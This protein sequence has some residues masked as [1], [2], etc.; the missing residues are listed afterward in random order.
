MVKKRG[1][2]KSLDALL[3]GSMS[4]TEGATD[5]LLENNKEKLCYLPLDLIQPGKY[6][7]R[8]EINH[9]T[10]E[11]LARSIRAQGVIQPIVVR[12][13]LGGRYE[14][15]AGERRWRAARLAELTE[16]PAIVRDIPDDAAIAIALIENIQREELNPIEEACALLRLLEEFSMTHGQVADAVGKSRTTVTNLLRL[17]SL[18]VEVK[19]MLEH[20]D[21]EMGHA[22]AL[23]TLDEAAQ[24]DAAQ[25]IINKNLSVRETEELVRRMQ[26]PN[27]PAM[28]KAIDPDVRRLQQD[29]SVRL[30]LAVAINCNAKGKGKVVIRYNDLTELDAI[31]EYFQVG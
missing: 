17:L 15:V 24:V 1:L 6:Q 12:H 8:H 19:K 25:A 11:D 4:H 28:P 9:E 18:A 13:L 29:L 27:L 14:I 22:R 16:I 7:P 5:H 26:M 10:L 20:G 30:K 3:V 23:L 31:L 2:G 21:I